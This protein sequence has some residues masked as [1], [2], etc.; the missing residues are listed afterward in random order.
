MSGSTSSWFLTGKRALPPH[1]RQRERNTKQASRCSEAAWF[2]LIFQ[3]RKVFQAGLL[4]CLLL[5]LRG[6]RA[7]EM[8][9]DNV[10]ADRVFRLLRDQVLCLLNARRRLAW[11]LR[12]G[13]CLLGHDRLCLHACRWLSWLRLRCAGLHGYT[14]GLHGN[15]SALCIG[16]S[17]SRVRRTG[18][19]CA[20]MKYAQ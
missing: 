20:R 16:A 9:D 18:Q 8:A 12:R 19:R 17:G 4:S 7:R 10:I 15:A 6:Y 13:L 11:R 2:L 5:L 14:A 3:I 1:T